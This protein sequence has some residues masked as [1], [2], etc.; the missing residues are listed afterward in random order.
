MGCAAGWPFSRSL[1]R[2]ILPVGHM[3]DQPVERIAHDDLAGE[4]AA[5]LYFGSR[6]LEHVAFFLAGGAADPVRPCLVDIAVAGGTGERAAAFADN[7][8][9]AIV[10]RA[11]HDVL[12]HV[13]V[14]RPLRAVVGD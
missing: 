8:L 10:E 14:E 12:A 2:S 5:G 11:M 13:Y 6:A 1:A 9:D 4:A 3:Y 7:A